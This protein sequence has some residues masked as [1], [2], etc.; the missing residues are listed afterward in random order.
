MTDEELYQALDGL[1]A[2]DTGCVDSGIHDEVL[3]QL[4][5]EELAK[6]LGP[7]QIVGPRLSAFAKTLLDPPYGLEDVASFIKWLADYMDIEL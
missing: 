7:C 6:D 1:F 2:Y 5:K 4:V 3:R